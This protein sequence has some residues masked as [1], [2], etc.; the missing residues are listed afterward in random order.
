[1]TNLRPTRVFHLGDVLSVTTFRL[2]SPRSLDGVYD[3]LRF[4]LSKEPDADSLAGAL[5]IAR[6]YL[7]QT[8]PQ[9]ESS[10][11]ED[12][13]FDNWQQWLGQQQQI[14]GEWIEVEQPAVGELGWQ[15]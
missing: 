7:L 12:V 2:V 15:A 6:A 14:L 13:G 4:L 5:V 1:M 8:H 11:A 9:L 3:L 10:V